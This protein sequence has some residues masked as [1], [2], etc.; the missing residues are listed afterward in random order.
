MTAL[1]EI[2][3]FNFTNSEEELLEY[4]EN[5]TPEEMERFLND[6]TVLSIL[7]PVEEPERSHPEAV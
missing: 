5:F 1:E 7:R 2:L 6:P 3:S 4:I